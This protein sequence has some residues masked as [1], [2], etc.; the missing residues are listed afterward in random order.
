MRFALVVDCFCFGVSVARFIDRSLFSA[1]IP[2]CL[3][4]P[5]YCAFLRPV[6]CPIRPVK[7]A[8]YTRPMK[9]I[10]LPFKH[11]AGMSRTVHLD[12]IYVVY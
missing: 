2:A 5:A 12:S 3:L 9:D 1:R 7:K 10:Y 4:T 8:W 6:E 11:Q